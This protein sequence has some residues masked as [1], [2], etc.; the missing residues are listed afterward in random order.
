MEGF[1]EKGVK[2]CN[3]ATVPFSVV[4]RFEVMHRPQLIAFYAVT[5]DEAVVVITRSLHLE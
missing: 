4:K 2:K 1:R 5:V 3:R